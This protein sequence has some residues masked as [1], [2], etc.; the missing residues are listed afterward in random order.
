MVKKEQSTLEIIPPNKE[1]LEIILFGRG[2]GESILVNFGNFR[3]AVID[4]FLNPSTGN[5]I[6]LDYLNK[7]NIPFKNIELVVAT[8]WHNDHIKG[9]SKILTEAN[10]NAKF[11]TSTIINDEK[12]NSYIACGNNIDFQESD[13]AET[14]E[15]SKI[16]DMIDNSKI[17][18]VLASHNKNLFTI[19]KNINFYAL[20]PQDNEVFEY[21]KQLKMPQIN[22]KKYDFSNDNCIS[23]VVWLELGNNIV[24]LGG[25][26]LNFQNNNK[27]GW[28]AIVDNHTLLGKADLFKVPHHGSVSSHNSEVWDKLLKER[29]CHNKWLIFDEK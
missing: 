19:A 8:H 12:F 1:E 26:L 29:L 25:D 10:S 16:L 24:L 22:E 7:I 18:V 14:S 2:Y 15:F 23:I 9:L 17:Q 3:Y 21:L 28:Q 5:P 20:S 6:A 13:F 11:V 4:S 27:R